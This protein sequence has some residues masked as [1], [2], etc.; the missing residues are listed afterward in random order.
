MNKSEAAYAMKLD[1]RAKAGDIFDWAFEPIRLRLGEGAWYTPDFLVVLNTGE[2][3]F[4]EYKG[5]WREAA[6]VRIKVAASLYPYFRF[7]AIQEKTVR[8]M[9]IFDVEEITSHHQEVS[10]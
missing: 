5:H 2:I 8:G 1:L 6:R 3:E 9:K 4:H 7:I 10:P